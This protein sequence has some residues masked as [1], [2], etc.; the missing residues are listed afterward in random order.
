[1]RFT[2]LA[3]ALAL[4]ACSEDDA[5]DQPPPA[6]DP[7]VVAPPIEQPAV[8]G[9]PDDPAIDEILEGARV[10]FRLREGSNVV[11]VIEREWQLVA[12]GSDGTEHELSRPP[13]PYEI[14]CGACGEPR[15]L[16]MPAHAPITFT[17][18]VVFAVYGP[19]PSYRASAQC[20]SF[21]ACVA[22]RALA[23]GTYRLVVRGNTFACDEASLT[24]PLAESAEV[25]CRR[26]DIP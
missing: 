14:G 10:F 1:M 21:Q 4:L 11:P 15:S 3:T 5:G 25:G 13:P 2:I 16:G 8:T 26:I 20:S 24:I 22:R 17:D 9:P 23:S 18:G 12:I 7:P 19:R 6:V